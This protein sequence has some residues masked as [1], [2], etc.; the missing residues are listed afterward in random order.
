MNNI[1]SQINNINT[2]F[3]INGNEIP[4]NAKIPVISTTSK[5]I[6][7]ELGTDSSDYLSYP[8][9]DKTEA[10]SSSIQKLHEA[11]KKIDEAKEHSKVNKLLGLLRS[12]LSLAILAGGIL[13]QLPWHGVLLPQWELLWPPALH[14]LPFAFIM[15]I[16]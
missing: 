2:M 3:S 13:V 6:F 12:A 7:K 4:V 14:I 15:H 11:S 1:V 16:A 9:K 5:A 8:F 10:L